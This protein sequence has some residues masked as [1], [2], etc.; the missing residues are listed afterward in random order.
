[1]TTTYP[2]FREESLNKLWD[3]GETNSLEII[4]NSFGGELPRGLDFVNVPDYDVHLRSVWGKPAFYSTALWQTLKGSWFW[5]GINYVFFHAPIIAGAIVAVNAAA[6]AASLGGYVEPS[7]DPHTININDIWAAGRH[8]NKAAGGLADAIAHENFHLIQA[9]DDRTSLSS[10]FDDNRA[11]V[12]MLFDKRSGFLKYLSSECELQARMFTVIS[13]AYIQHGRMP[14]NKYELWACLASQGMTP[15][16]S[17]LRKTQTHPDCAR[18]FAM[19]PASQDYVDHYA[20]RMA[21]K[22][23]DQVQNGIDVETQKNALWEKVYPFLYGDMLEIMGDRLGQK[24][25][26]GS[27]NVQL[28]EI[29]MKAAQDNMDGAI[30]D[31]QTLKQMKKAA[32]MM[33]P[34][35]AAGLM[36]DIATGRPYKEYSEKSV[37]IPAGHLRTAAAFTLAANPKLGPRNAAYALQAATGLSPRA[38]KAQMDMGERMRRAKP[39]SVPSVNRRERRNLGLRACFGAPSFG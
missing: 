15:P 20:D 35:D 12:N 31:A 34:E 25:M 27:H 3:K 1:M 32:D 38:W 23:L 36:Q 11:G 26:G 6:A 22:Q 9:Y 13:N 18:A 4:K 29:F 19:F 8:F 5:A 14:L 28:R 17:I 10:A 21:A 33:T 39:V 7:V 30:S 24:R 16:D 37:F 2:T